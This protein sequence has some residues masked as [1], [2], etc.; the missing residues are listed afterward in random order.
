MLFIMQLNMHLAHEKQQLEEWSSGTWRCPVA[1][2]DNSM[3]QQTP[4]HVCDL[5]QLSECKKSHGPGY[6]YLPNCMQSVP[7]DPTLTWNYAVKEILR[8]VAPA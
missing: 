3:S 7:Y 6:F 8:N 5:H 1:V 4:D 2:H